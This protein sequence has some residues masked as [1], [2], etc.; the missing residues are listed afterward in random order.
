[1]PFSPA[2]MA[3]FDDVLGRPVVA[4]LMVTSARL[5]PEAQLEAGVVQQLVDV[6]QLDATAVALAKGAAHRR[7]TNLGR[8]KKLVHSE[9]IHL[10]GRV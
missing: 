7:S 9:A 5:A 4:P 6:D 1:M 8:I 10:A 2:M 3:L